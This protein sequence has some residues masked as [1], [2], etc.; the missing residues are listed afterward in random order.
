MTS[1]I[2]L[3]SASELLAEASGLAVASDTDM[4]LSD[5]DH[6]WVD[7]ALAA[8]DQAVREAIEAAARIEPRSS[9]TFAYQ[10]EGYASGWNAARD[11]MRTA[12]RSLLPN[13]EKR[14]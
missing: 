6:V 3:R 2:S 13:K 1:P 14:G 11:S 8:I 5:V 12:I 7:Q 4:D 10:A 9:E